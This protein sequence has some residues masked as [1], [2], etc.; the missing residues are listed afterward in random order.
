MTVS[1]GYSQ[2][3][4]SCAML[5]FACQA[6]AVFI[7]QVNDLSCLSFVLTRLSARHCFPNYH[8][9][10]LS[11][12]IQ[13]CRILIALQKVSHDLAFYI[14]G[15][16]NAGLLY[17]KIKK[18]QCSNLIKTNSQTLANVTYMSESFSIHLL[19]FFNISRKF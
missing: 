9:V 18:I 8:Y 12:I 11:A 14:V 15:W 1:N 6:L 2:K 5:N 3:P 16:K 17:N 19:I 13:E 10:L 4:I 7:Y